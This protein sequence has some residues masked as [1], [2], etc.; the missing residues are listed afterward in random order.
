MMHALAVV[1]KNIRNAMEKKLKFL[2]SCIL[3]VIASIASAQVTVHIDEEVNQNLRM[4][5]AQ[6]DT[7]RISGFRIQIESNSDRS[8]TN[9]AE[10]NFKNKYPKYANTVYVLYQQPNYKVRVGDFLREIEAQEMLAEIRKEF[11]LAI[12]VRDY[13]RTPKID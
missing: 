4:K 1:E 5:N 8:I 13:I 3:L 10:A 9:K 12:M 11:P 2:I 7:N 6:I